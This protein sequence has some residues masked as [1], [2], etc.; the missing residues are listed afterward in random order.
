MKVLIVANYNPGHFSPFVS[1]QVEALKKLGVDFDFFGIVGK[2]IMGYLKNLPALKRKI[3]YYKP[4][5]IHAHYGLSGMLATLQMNVPVVITFH[6]G[7]TLSP[8][9]NLLSSIAAKRAE[10][11][12]YVAQH[13]RDLSYL[14][15]TRFSIIPCGID[16]KLFVPK[17]K[18]EARKHLGLISNR[19]YILFG[20]AFDNLRKNY[21]LLKSAIELLP[22]NAE[23]ECI[24]MKGMTREQCVDYMNACDVFALP[25]KSE[26]SPQA[27]KEAMACNCPIVGTDVADIRHL[28]G[29]VS[30]HFIC[31]FDPEDVADKLSLA[32]S[33]NGRTNGRK[34][35]FELHLTNEQVAQRVY[36]VYDKVLN[37]SVLITPPD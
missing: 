26:G 9:P 3:K 27:L 18:L 22:S 34:R 6:N 11:G 32:L 1:E 21:P 4:D 24:E 16:S 7:E 20:G 5:L 33:F 28:L 2:G 14:K 31:S 35:I 25:T 30:G 10:W 15:S 29:N 17:D 13:I 8:I 37:K 12:I 23:I 36:E 19:R